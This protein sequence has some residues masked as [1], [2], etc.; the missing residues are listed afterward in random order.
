MHR[1]TALCFPN[2]NQK[3]FYAMNQ[4]KSITE[5]KFISRM[6]MNGK[7]GILIAAMFI[8]V[9]ISTLAPF[10][11]SRM[12]PIT[13]NFSLILYY[14]VTF[15]VQLLIYVLQVGVCLFHLHVACEMPCQISD[16]FYGF[17]NSPDKAIKLGLFFTLINFV[18]MIPSYFVQPDV[19]PILRQLATSSSDNIELLQM[20]YSAMLPSLLVFQL[21]SL[22]Y[23]IVTISF[24]PALYMILDFPKDNITTILK[25]CW[26][27]MSRNR[28]RY[29]ILNLSFVPM[30]LLSIILCGIPLLWIIPH[31]QV[32]FA[33]FYL[34]LITNRPSQNNVS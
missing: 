29:F 32:S 8:E 7:M 22:V 2:T 6:Q 27:V 3:G 14:I 4:H 21:C 12:I 5:L 18:C 10:L 15:I 24:F 28:L 1:K 11:V 19:V 33:N 25:R 17:K 13:S 26:K 30:I 20:L 16:L 31:M 34:D 9:I 23:F